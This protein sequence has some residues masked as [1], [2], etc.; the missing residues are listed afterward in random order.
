MPEALAPALAEVRELLLG[1]DLVRAVAAGRRRGATPRVT[2]A[3]LRAVQVSAGPRLLLTEAGEGGP[4]TRTLPRDGT[5]AAV[6]DELL[7]EPFGNWHVETRHGTVQLRVTKKGEAQVHRAV[8]ERK[9][10]PEAH[11][12]AKQH[13]LAPDDAL[14]GV[15]GADAAKRRQV[16]AFLRLLRPVV[17]QVTGRALR[18]VDLGCGNGYLTL[19]AHRWLSGLGP[20][21]TVGVDVRD[22]VVARTGALA[23][24]LGETGVRFVAA[25]AGSWQPEE[26]PDIVLALHACDTATDEALARAV[27]W[28]AP[29]VLAA[30]CCHHDLRAQTAGRSPADVDPA[31]RGAFRH[32]ILRQRLLDTLTDSLRTDLLRLAGYRSEAVELVDPEHTPRNTLLRAVRTD[33]PAPAG[34]AD[35]VTSTCEALGVSPRLAQLLGR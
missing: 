7:A 20:V 18:V 31:L 12:R 24:Q 33:V 8:A 5:G 9:A 3:E 2:R 29:V 22:D 13:L 17:P 34:L 30:P 28:Q 26:A 16:D 1:G 4:A 35:E 11:D 21:E 14:F 6:V 23:E 15:I 10:A 27:G 25:E 32:G 19:A